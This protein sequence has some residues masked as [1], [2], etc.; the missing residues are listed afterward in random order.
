MIRFFRT[1]KSYNTRFCTMSLSAVDVG[2][3]TQDILFYRED[4]PLG[5]STKMVLPSPTA[6]VA[7][8]IDRARS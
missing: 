2:A 6:L 4:I 8:R 3:V 7:G 1:Y 5:G